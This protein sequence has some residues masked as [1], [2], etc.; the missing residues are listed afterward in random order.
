MN[1]KKYFSETMVKWFQKNKRDLPFRRTKNPYHIWISEIMAQQTQIDTLIPYS[2]RFILKFPDIATLAEASEEEVLKSWEGLGY[3]SRAKNLHKAAKKIMTDYNGCFPTDFDDILALPGIGPYT[4]G[5]IGSIALGLHVPAVD[6]NVLRVI[7][8]FNNW[9]DDIA[10]NST[11]RKVTEWVTDTIPETPGDFNESL[12]E[13]GALICT[14]KSPSC[15]ICPVREHCA[16]FAAGTVDQLP[17]KTKKQKQKKMN[18]EVGLLYNKDGIY[19][20]KRPETGLL[21]GLWGFPICEAEKEKGKAVTALLEKN[22]GT[23]LSGT[24]IGKSRHIFSH[25]IWEMSLYA[26]KLNSSTIKEEKITYGD[27]DDF[28]FSSWEDL[29]EKYT[30]PTAFSKLLPYIEH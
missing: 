19:I 13:L 29:N 7:T 12:M 14:P 23:S 22:T 27:T 8:R 3:Y 21:S 2:E 16:A 15:L 1:L 28:F 26:F 30:L 9:N 10:Q 18:M 17:V 24:C 20:C 6:G 11:K 25:I 5:A 4:G